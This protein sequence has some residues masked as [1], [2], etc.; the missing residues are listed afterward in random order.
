MKSSRNTAAALAL[1]ELL[2]AAAI[3]G[4]LIAVTLAVYGSILNT[5]TAQNRWREKIMPAAAGLDVIIRDLACAVIPFGITN[6]P[7]TAGLAET[8]DKIFQISFYSAFPTRSAR[9]EAS[10][11]GDAS[12]RTA[13]S[14]DRGSYSI[15]H[16]C[17]FL[18]TTG[19]TDEFVLV[20]QSNPYRVPSPNPLSAGTE[21]WRG[22]KKLD[23][24]FFDGSRWTNQWGGG[25]GTNALPRSARISMVAGENDA[26]EIGSEVF[27]NAARQ[28]V[29][30]KS[31]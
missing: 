20:R 29:P 10:G 22:I 16:V 19:R 24:A 18:L 26:R 30:G 13:S 8:N 17:Y 7:F 31:K 5:V 12:E 11:R 25:R 3:A 1:I 23:I 15:S 6:Q 14:N 4:L 21:Q 2:I 27:I 9:S 28:I